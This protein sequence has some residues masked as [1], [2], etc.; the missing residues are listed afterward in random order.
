MEGQHKIFLQNLPFM[1]H[2]SSNLIFPLRLKPSWRGKMCT[3]AP[4]VSHSYAPVHSWIITKINMVMNIHLVS[5][6]LNFHKDSF[7]HC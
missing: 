7:I 4:Q 6:S 2:F 5:S 3:P 1:T